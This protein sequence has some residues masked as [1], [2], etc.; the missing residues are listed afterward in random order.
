MVTRLRW[1]FQPAELPDGKKTCA[2][3]SDHDPGLEEGW[4][5]ATHVSPFDPEPTAGRKPP[6]LL[7][8]RERVTIG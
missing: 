5:F 1:S 3:E 8:F 2:Q 4:P 7:A 6:A